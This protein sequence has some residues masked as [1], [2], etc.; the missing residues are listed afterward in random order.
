M[1]ESRSTLKQ[2]FLDK[3]YRHAY[4]EDFLNTKIATQIRVLREQRGW[5]QAELAKRIGTKQAGVARLENVNYSS[6]KIE[7]LRKIARAFD[8]R[9]SGGWETFGSFLDE[10]EQFSRKSLER[11]SFEE[12]AAFKES[13]T[14][15]TYG[16][17]T[18]EVPRASALLSPVPPAPV[19]TGI[20]MLSY[21]Q[22]HQGPLRQAQQGAAIA[23]SSPLSAVQTG[24]PPLTQV[25]R[26]EIAAS[27]PLSAVQAGGGQLHRAL[28]TPIY[29]AA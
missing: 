7:T 20:F 21:G 25:E 5:T 19:S 14:Q 18:Q 15:E 26:Q 13:T 24:A 12:D 29:S 17:Q 1:N 3:E 11:P 4:A 22:P 28:D 2:E 27:S 16:P 23:A 10:L 6:W 9:F 8:L